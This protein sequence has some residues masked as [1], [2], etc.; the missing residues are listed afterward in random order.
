MDLPAAVVEAAAKIDWVQVAQTIED[1][2]PV[3]RVVQQ[4]WS[5]ESLVDILNGSIAVPDSVI[6]DALAERLAGGNNNITAVEIASR[7]TGRVEIKA[8]TKRLGRVEVSGII[9]EMV[10]DTNGTHMTF[11]VKERALKDHGLGSWFFSRL[12]LSMVQNLFGKIELGDDL[13][14]TIKGNRVRVDFGPALEKG[15]LANTRLHGHRLLDLFS[16]QSATP[17]E[18]YITFKT[19]VDLPDDIVQMIINAV[20]R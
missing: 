17:H 18:G 7:E 12:S 8:T 5:H 15:D 6:N 9:E 19:K 10:H 3:V 1:Y 14:T 11:R 13:P 16:I 4:T 20:G 2:E